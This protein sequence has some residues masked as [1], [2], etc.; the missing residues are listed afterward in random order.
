MADI[1]TP[2]KRSWLMSRIKGKETPLGRLVYAHLRKE[3]VYFEKHYKKI[4]DS[5]EIALPRKKRVVFI[6][7]DF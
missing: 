5:P 2:E 6:D 4:C 1:F 7:G 3:R